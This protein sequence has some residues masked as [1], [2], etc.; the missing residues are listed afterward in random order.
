MKPVRILLIDDGTCAVRAV[1]P[2]LRAHATSCELDIACIPAAQSCDGAHDVDGCDA[3]LVPVARGDSGA[4]ERLAWTARSVVS[5]PVLAV[6]GADEE[7][8]AADVMAA[9]AA[10][11]IVAGTMSGATMLRVIAGAAARLAAEAAL[12]RTEERLRLSTR[13]ADALVYEMDLATGRSSFGEHAPASLGYE[14]AELPAL[15]DEWID[16]VHPEDQRRTSE[17]WQRAIS[18]GSDECLLEY[19][20]RRPDGSWTVVRDCGWVIRDQNGRPARLTGAVTDISERV[21]SETALRKSEARFRLITDTLRTVFY[22]AETKPLRMSYMSPAFEEIWGVDHHA[23]HD[24]TGLLGTDVLE[25]FMTTV[26]PDDRERAR[27]DIARRVRGESVYSE[28]RIRRRD[29]EIRWIGD[30]SYPLRGPSGDVEQIVG[31][32]EDITQRVHAAQELRRSEEQLSRILETITDAIVI[33]DDTGVLTFANLAI[34]S[35]GGVPRSEI[36]GRSFF[37]EGWRFRSHDGRS[38]APAAL[39]AALVLA[40]GEP[41]FDSELWFTRPDGRAIL[42][43]VNAA[44]LRVADGAIAEVIVSV[45][46]VTAERASAERLRFQASLLEAVGEAVTATDLAGRITYWNRQAERCTGW[47]AAEVLGRSILEVS[48]PPE[49]RDSF[50]EVLVAVARGERYAGEHRILRRDGSSYPAV[51]TG[52]PICDDAGAV[53]G[54][55]AASTDLSD[56]KALEEQ[57]H[58]AQRMEAVGRLAG[59][60]AHDFNNI[61]TSIKGYTH[62]MLEALPEADAL[63][64]DAEEIARAADRA[65]GLTRQLLAFSRKQVM[66]PRVLDL[67]GAV[68]R[69]ESMLLRLIGEDVELVCRCEPNVGRVLADPGQIEQVVLNLAVNARDA[70]PAGGRLLIEVENERQCDSLQAVEW[71]ILRVTDT[72][73]GIP[74]AALPYIFEPFFTTKSMGQGTGLG[75]SM[76][77]GIIS[78]SGGTVHVESVEG[79]G[80]VFEIRLPRAAGPVEE[81]I[82]ASVVSR[83]ARG[84]TILIVEDEDSVRS[85]T[86]RTLRRIG[87]DVLEANNGAEALRLSERRQEPIHLL[88]TDVVMPR[89]SGR[90]VAERL[91]LMRPDMAVLFM[92][93]YTA[94]VIARHGILEEGRLFLE[95]PFTPTALA[96][97]VRE[98]LDGVAAQGAARPSNLSSLV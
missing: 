81:A 17:A 71:V 45:R 39:P 34:E 73:I 8:A 3:V 79:R 28:Y 85:L 62:F 32:A 57:L 95:K 9:G 46:D 6:L 20:M 18:E 16:L 15:L 52:T 38:V 89:M 35:I 53:V 64:P 47:R 26:H 42:I 29:G 80:T 77:Y 98:V 97:R 75:L 87:Y 50:V 74:P 88:L 1:I 22:L 84:E 82:A 21:V 68:R 2:A 90:E 11:C 49:S 63:R 93:G 14:P 65:A 36:I 69:L 25:R 24:V 23:I 44:P 66:Q 19:R 33:V 12:A 83:P 13:A 27:D 92:S 5:A 61:L 48:A 58:Q 91:A 56:M 86:A 54:L 72:G 60:V 96:A 70:M 51:I 37:S 10:D 59:G 41:V 31:I 7:D 43:S 40:T 76:V 55:V 94:D 67:G 30:R 78:Q 4:L